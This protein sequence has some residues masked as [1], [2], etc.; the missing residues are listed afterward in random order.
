MQY[1]NIITDTIKAQ[2]TIKAPTTK[3][4][5]KKNKAALLAIFFGIFSIHSLYLGNKLKG[6]I[7]LIFGLIGFIVFYNSLGAASASSVTGLPISL[8]IGFTMLFASGVWALV[9]FIRILE[10]SILPFEGFEN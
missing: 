4:K 9:D 3:G 1:V 7:Q 10:G 8:L 2:K 6:L 5:K